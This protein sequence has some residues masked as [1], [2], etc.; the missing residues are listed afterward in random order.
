MFNKVFH[1]KIKHFKFCHLKNST[2]H[3]I[4]NSP[5]GDD[6]GDDVNWHSVYQ[7][8]DILHQEF[9]F[10]YFIPGGTRLLHIPEVMPYIMFVKFVVE[11]SLQSQ[12][13]A[14]RNGQHKCASCPRHS[15][16]KHHEMF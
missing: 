12:C 13:T 7:V 2:T 3:C 15:K 14:P 4:F 11:P 5:L 9:P 6:T 16:W 10:V 8:F 1:H